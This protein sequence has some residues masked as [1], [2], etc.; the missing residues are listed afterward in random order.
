[1]TNF[2]V[3]VTFTVAAANAERFLAR[4]RQQAED[5][6]AKE[7]GCGRFDV[8]TDPAQPGRVFLYELYDDRGAFDLHLASAHFKAFD[9][10]VAPIVLSKQVDT[11]TRA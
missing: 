2:V 10:E 8:C 3:T 1:M 7:T 5:S 11:W 9:A 4:V 6:L